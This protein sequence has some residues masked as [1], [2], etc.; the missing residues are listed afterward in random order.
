MKIPAIF[1]VSTKNS[2]KMNMANNALRK[3][4]SDMIQYCSYE[5]FQGLYKV[6]NASGKTIL[7][8]TMD[9]GFTVVYTLSY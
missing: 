6:N 3:D 2:E 4:G 9:R 8:G 7:K 1:W 5:T